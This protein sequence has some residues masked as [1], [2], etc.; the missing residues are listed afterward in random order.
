MLNYLFLALAIVATVLVYVFIPTVSPWLI[1]PILLGGFVAAILLYV[2]FLLV[3][4]FFLPKRK[5]I[6]RTKPICARMIYLTMDWLMSLLR[7]RVKLTGTEL[8]PDEPCILVSN[9]QSD[10]DPMAVLAVWKGRRVAFISKEANFKIPIVGN[11]IHHAGFLAIDRGNGM[12][13]LRTLKQAAEM[14][15]AEGLDI[16]IYPE[17]TRSKTGELLRFK[18]GAFLL[19]K[20]AEAPIVVMSTNGTGRISKN[21]LIRRTDVELRILAVIDRQ[22]VIETE[23]EELTERVREIIEK[24]L[25]K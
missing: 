23:R 1:L 10:F 4:S 2:V 11:F 3:W 15:K 21:F 8:L 7:I 20:R 14:Q 5:P 25:K 19:A 24:D 22:T 13:A 18:S 9:H 16:G 17:G 6:K 12:R